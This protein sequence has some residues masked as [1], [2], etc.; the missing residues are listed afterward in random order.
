VPCAGGARVCRLK[1]VRAV[2]SGADEGT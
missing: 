2:L 1:G